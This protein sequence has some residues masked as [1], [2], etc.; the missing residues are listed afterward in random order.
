MTLKTFKNALEVNN[1]RLT[2]SEMKYIAGKFK[3]PNESGEDRL[4]YKQLSH[5]LGLHASNL[6]LIQVSS[7][8]LANYQ[9]A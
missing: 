1:V 3:V 7:T 6:D 5:G 2:T 4:S 9:S 8:S